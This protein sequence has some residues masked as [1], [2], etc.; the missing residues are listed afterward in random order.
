MRGVR[1]KVAHPAMLKAIF[2]SKR[3]NDAR[4]LADL[5][6]CNYFPECYMADREIRDRRRVLRYRNT[7]V[8]QCTQ[9]KNKM[10][11]M[12]METGIP[13]N[14]QRL[15]NSKTYFEELL[16]TK[17]VLMPEGLPRLLR[18][19]RNVVEILRTMNRQ[20]V[21]VLETDSVLAERVARLMT[22]PGG[23]CHSG[24]DMG[25]RNRRCR[26][27]CIRQSRHQLLRIVRSGAKL[28]W[29]VTTNADIQTAKQ[30][31]ANDSDRSRKGRS[32]LA[33]RVCPALRPGETEGQS[34]PCYAR[35]RTKAGFVLISY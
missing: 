21:H 32:S 26:Q 17:S 15:H 11:G 14:K 5:L 19:G 9:T 1:V 8:R 31:F 4:K 27:V 2:T 24:A 3:K 30:A 7:L 20:L 35:N 25:A 13:Y 10:A 18:L 29:Q 22:I 6:R 23:W 28:G 16:E 12:L 34:E 33:S